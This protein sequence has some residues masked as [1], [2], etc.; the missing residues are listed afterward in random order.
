MVAPSERDPF[1]LGPH[2]RAPFDV[3]PIEPPTVGDRPPA[4]APDVA[5]DAETPKAAP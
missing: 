3:D 2:D 4:E 5:C 1:K